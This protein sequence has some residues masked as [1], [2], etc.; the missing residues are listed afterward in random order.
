MPTIIATVNG[1]T[2]NS[3]VTLAWADA[4]HVDKLA[5]AGMA[6]ETWDRENRERALLSATL[7]LE[8]EHWQGQPYDTWT[9][10]NLWFP[11]TDSR[12]PAGVLEIPDRIEMATAELALAMLQDL[13]APDPIAVS[14][15]Q[16]KGIAMAAGGGMSF[17]FTKGANDLPLQ[18]QRLIMPYVKRGGRIVTGEA[19]AR[20]WHEGWVAT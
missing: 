13:R 5:P 6:W 12:T 10:Q 7:R 19:P 15:A 9:P 1:A 8:Q 20:H 11:R 17:A 4:Y 16:R 2:S 14:E 3:Y 18:V